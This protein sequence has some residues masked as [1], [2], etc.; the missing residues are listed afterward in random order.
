MLTGVIWPIGVCIRDKH[1]W[2]PSTA[3]RIGGL[4]WLRDI[5]G[6][7]LLISLDSIWVSPLHSLNYT[8]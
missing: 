8:L 1:I 7:T 5:L 2:F 4:I 6:R 3:I